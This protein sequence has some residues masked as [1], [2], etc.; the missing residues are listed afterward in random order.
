MINLGIASGPFSCFFLQVH[1]EVIEDDKFWWIFIL[2]AMKLL[3]LPSVRPM[4]KR[5]TGEQ[6]S[7]RFYPGQTSAA[8]PGYLNSQYLNSHIILSK[9]SINQSIN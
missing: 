2:M 4:G 1:E 8:F 9:L 7:P 5:R 3:F 6:I